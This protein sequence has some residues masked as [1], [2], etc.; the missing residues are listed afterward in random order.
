ML[1]F[2]LFVLVHT[3]FYVFACN[4]WEPFLRDTFIPKEQEQAA[5][6]FLHWPRE[7][8]QMFVMHLNNWWLR[9]DSQYWWPAAFTKSS[10]SLLIQHSCHDIFLT[11]ISSY[12]CNG[13]CCAH[14]LV[15]CMTLFTFICLCVI[16]QTIEDLKESPLLSCFSS[17]FLPL[18]PDPP[19]VSLVPNEQQLARLTDYVAFLENW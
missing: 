16:E 4:H 14:I 3:A 7:T 10:W 19:P 6:G 8:V 18:S 5:S 12:I 17:A 1:F 2:V 13:L 9:N 15:L 11:C